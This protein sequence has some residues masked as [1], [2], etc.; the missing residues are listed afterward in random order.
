MSNI[1]IPA[2]AF[3]PPDSQ[4]V[5]E[6]IEFASACFTDGSECECPITQGMETFLNLT[7]DLSSYVEAYCLNP[8]SDDSC[9]FGYCSNPDIAGPLVRIASYIT[10]I[11]L[12]LLIFYSPE[13]ASAALWS[14]IL[15]MYSFLIT[16]WISISQARLSRLYGVLA[17]FM[18]G[19]PL[20]LYLIVFAVMSFWTPKHRLNHLL[21]K[22]HWFTRIL[23]IGA[24]LLWL[25]LFIFSTVQATGPFFAQ[26]SCDNLYSHTTVGPLTVYMLVVPFLLFAETTQEHLS[27]GYLVIVLISLTFLSWVVAILLQRKNIWRPGAK[28]RPHFVRIWDITGQQYSFIH[29]LLLVVLPNAYWISAIEVTYLLTQLLA[30]KEFISFGQVLALFVALP[31]AL[32]VV[33]LGPKFWIWFTQLAWVRQLSQKW[34]TKKPKRS[35]TMSISS[36]EV[37]A[38][39]DKEA[40]RSIL[41]TSSDTASTGYFSEVRTRRDV[42]RE[43]ASPISPF[44]P[45][46]DDSNGLLGSTTG[47]SGKSGFIGGF[48]SALNDPPESVPTLAMPEPA[49]F[50]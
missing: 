7:Q 2:P 47:W 12:S 24:G 44:P 26:A 10:N 48:S 45:K 32:S 31:P 28:W 18:V 8:P 33:Q 23:I 34:R 37:G 11:C 41:A 14:Q 40:D 5:L 25:A 20:S 1:S 4:C 16:S 46:L 50:S 39:Y 38:G 15:T 9:S 6:F 43:V 27:W 30:P 19:S 36:V 21:G 29:F 49:L 42:M 35:R 13:D 3:F 22:G 17:A